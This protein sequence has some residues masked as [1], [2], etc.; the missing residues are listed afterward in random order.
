MNTFVLIKY[1]LIPNYE[2][3]YNLN[4]KIIYDN[5]SDKEKIFFSMRMFLDG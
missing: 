2:F 3:I 5:I 4:S 1:C